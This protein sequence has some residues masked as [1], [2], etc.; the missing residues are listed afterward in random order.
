M[1]RGSARP[2]MESELARVQRALAASEDA[3]WKMEF[4]L[5]VAQ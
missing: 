1:R 4:E 2:Q 5:E 3:R